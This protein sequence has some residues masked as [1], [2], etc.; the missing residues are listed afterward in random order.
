MECISNASRVIAISQSVKEKFQIQLTDPKLNVIYN[1][2]PISG[3]LVKREKCI[4][5]DKNIKLIISGRIDP[6]KGHKELIEAISLIVE[7]GIV[8]IN[9]KIVGSSQNKEYEKQIKEM[10]LQKNRKI[11]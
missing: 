8:N 4:F 1:G 9:L 11:C 10:V 2:V 3:Y 7:R 6:G 5:S